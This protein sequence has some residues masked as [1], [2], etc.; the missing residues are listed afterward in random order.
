MTVGLFDRL[1]TRHFQRPK[2]DD[3]HYKSA[4]S[5]QRLDRDLKSMRYFFLA[6]VLLLLSRSEPADAAGLTK[7]VIASRLIA[8][9]PNDIQ[10]IDGNDVVFRDGTRLPIDDGDNDKDATAWLA[11]PSIKDMFRF[12]YPVG[13][14]ASTPEVHSDP[15][16]ARNA[17]FF[18]KIYGRCGDHKTR[19]VMVDIVWL[20]SRAQQRV[21]MTV[22]VT[23]RNGVAERLQKI[24]DALDA[25][26][27]S[28]DRFIHPP[29]GG[30]VCRSIA[31][32]TNPSA[33]GY[34][35]AVDVAVRHA[36]YWRWDLARDRD[37][38]APAYRNDVPPEIVEIFEKHG[39]IWGGRWHHYDTMHF[40]YRPE[41]FSD[42]ASV[43]G[44]K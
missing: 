24:S 9:Y 41:L 27:S 31:G 14:M 36:N 40:E 29:A 37:A 30:Y 8:A 25:L 39:F 2:L 22:T 11:R 34:G 43:I 42:P 33:H 28:F 16:R 13:A 38:V 12:A 4:S 18:E 17:R 6:F 1:P 20:K 7:S 44:A 21:P 23:A 3:G 10:T 26:P 35:I 32:T 19:D 5:R 15:G